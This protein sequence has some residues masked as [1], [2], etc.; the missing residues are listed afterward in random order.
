MR[1][2]PK[3][4]KAAGQGLE[5]TRC[6]TAKDGIVQ[7]HQLISE[8]CMFT[9]QLRQALDLSNRGGWR[10]V[11]RRDVS[12]YHTADVPHRP[13]LE[14]VHPMSPSPLATFAPRRTHPSTLFLLSV[15]CSRGSLCWIEDARSLSKFACV[16]DLGYRSI[17]CIP[18]CCG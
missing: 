1:M 18:S 12:E 6:G 14:F 17:P 2:D 11:L 3:K 7:P 5:R 16:F 13:S 8:P 4:Q 15:P 10:S 9:R